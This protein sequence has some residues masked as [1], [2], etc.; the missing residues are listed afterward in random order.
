MRIVVDYHVDRSG[1]KARW[2]V[3]LT[4]TNHPIDFIH[5]KMFYIFNLCVFVIL[6]ITTFF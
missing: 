2:R 3:Q 5:L 1:V 6:S 4:D